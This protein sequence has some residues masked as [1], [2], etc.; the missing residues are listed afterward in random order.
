MVIILANEREVN[1][2]NMAIRVASLPSRTEGEREREVG[3]VDGGRD[4]PRE[5]EEQEERQK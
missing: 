2:P 4:G 5:S 3:K 1:S